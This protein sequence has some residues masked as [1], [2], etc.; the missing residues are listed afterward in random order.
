MKNRNYRIDTK[1]KV[2]WT[3][4][5]VGASWVGRPRITRMG[6]SFYYVNN[7][8]VYVHQNG[9]CPHLEHDIKGQKRCSLTDLVAEYPRALP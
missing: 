2:V 3:L 5:E 9:S 1:N 4:N 8:C 7:S 6:K